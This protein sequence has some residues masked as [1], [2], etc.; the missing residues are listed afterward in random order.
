MN[1]KPNSNEVCPSPDQHFSQ[2]PAISS[3]MQDASQLGPDKSP[4]T[5]GPA[6]GKQETSIAFAAGFL[7]PGVVVL[8]ALSPACPRER[9]TIQLFRGSVCGIVGAGNYL[10]GVFVERTITETLFNCCHGVPWVSN[11][12]FNFFASKSNF[13]GVISTFSETF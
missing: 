6:S 1:Y 12:D 10:P 3:V 8:S 4:P 2:H 11:S 9:C 7:Q 5:R 13:P